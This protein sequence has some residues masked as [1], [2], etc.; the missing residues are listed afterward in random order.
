MVRGLFR[1][2][3]QETVLGVLEQSV[4]FV[5][6]ATIEGL[7]RSVTFDSTA[8]Q[9]ANL[10]LAS[11]S[12]EL[13]GPDAP[14]IVGLSEDTTCYVSTAFEAND[15]SADIVVH[16][17]AHV[18]HNC[19]RARVGLPWTRRREWLLE[20]EY[21]ERET[22]AY[23]CEAYSMILATARSAADRRALGAEFGTS[24]A[25]ADDAVEAS[26]VV[27]VVSEAV[28]ARNG[29]KVIHAHCAPPKRT[30]HQS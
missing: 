21:R 3:E 6:E 11:A 24:F 20:I 1:V 27:E 25:V 15:P 17:A 26:K 28:E 14:N 7:I 30:G 2:A 19:K 29:W 13:L 16:E 8:W 9:L 23:A 12:A 5:T 18:F 10:Y 22:F 4:V